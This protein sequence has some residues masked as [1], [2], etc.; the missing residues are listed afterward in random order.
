MQKKSQP[1]KLLPKFEQR[2]LFIGKCAQNV[3]Q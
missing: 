3:K 1:L 2:I